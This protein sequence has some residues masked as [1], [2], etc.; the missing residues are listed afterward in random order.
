MTF[1]EGFWPEL[2]RHARVGARSKRR[3]SSVTRT[4]IS[5]EAGLGEPAE[6]Q[7]GSDSVAALAASP[8]ADNL[9]KSR[10][11]RALSIRPPR[12]VTSRYIR[13]AYDFP[14]PPSAVP[15]SK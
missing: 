11:G 13:A 7:A 1:P 9:R 12:S 10:L 4:A 5:P 6:A 14:I 8:A 3:F 15:P 2:G